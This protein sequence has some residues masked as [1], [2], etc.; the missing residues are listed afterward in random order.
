MLACLGMLIIDV[1]V[2]PAGE[3][4]F[5]AHSG[6][7]DWETAPKGKGQLWRVRY[8]PDSEQQSGLA[9]RFT[10]NEVWVRFEG[11]PPGDWSSDEIKLEHSLHT[12][13]GDCLE[14]MWPGYEVLARQKVEGSQAL[15]VVS[16]H[17]VRNNLVIKTKPLPEKTW[18]GFELLGGYALQADSSGVGVHVDAGGDRKWTSWVP[19]VD[20]GVSRAL[21]GGNHCGAV[22][23]IRSFNRG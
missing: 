10:P 12:R 1:C 11:K 14:T 23:G 5:C 21:M 20:L 9:W 7:P 13:A 6:P 17:F 15:E 19:H 16:T 8:E 18:L 2:S 22:W 3:L 4:R